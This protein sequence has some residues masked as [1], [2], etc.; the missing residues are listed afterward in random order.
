MSVISLRRRTVLA[1]ALFSSVLFVPAA[2]AQDFDP[3]ARCNWLT[4]AYALG[5]S[6]HHASRA[7]ASTRPEIDDMFRHIW[8]CSS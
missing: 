6:N 8:D 3:A 7:W 4:V 2:Y 5:Q 1:A